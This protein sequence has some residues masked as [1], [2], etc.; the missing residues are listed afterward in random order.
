MPTWMERLAILLS[1]I[2]FEDV[3][4]SYANQFSPVVRQ[5]SFDSYPEVDPNARSKM[6]EMLHA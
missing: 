1:D 6:D 4:T 3:F 2:I 5:L